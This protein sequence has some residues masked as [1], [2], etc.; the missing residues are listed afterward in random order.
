MKYVTFYG[1]LYLFILRVLWFI[2]IYSVEAAYDVLEEHATFVF[3]ADH[4]C[5]Q[6]KI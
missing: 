3:R 4:R 1:V 6:T 2:I 5:E